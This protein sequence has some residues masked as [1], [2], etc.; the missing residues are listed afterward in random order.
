MEDDDTLSPGID[1]DM[2]LA[3]GDDAP[4]RFDESTLV[5]KKAEIRL[6]YLPRAFLEILTGARVSGR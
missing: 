5:E 3:L 6:L 4:V 2:S 1:E